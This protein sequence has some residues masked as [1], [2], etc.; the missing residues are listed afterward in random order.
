MRAP[1]AMKPMTPMER[2]TAT[3]ISASPSALDAA[4]WPAGAIVLRTAPDEVI[5]TAAV[6]PST[7]DDPHTIIEPETSLC[8]VW[9]TMSAALDYLARE[10]DWELPVAR[11]AFA[12]GAIAGL[13]VKL[14]FEH[15]RVLFVVP[16]PF[17]VDFAKR[18][19]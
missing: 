17:A 8:A 6:G 3:R 11:P 12:Q 7:V 16:G 1:E 19:R 10:C 14:W 18:L 4:T 2:L 13:P 9:M 5:V 15:D